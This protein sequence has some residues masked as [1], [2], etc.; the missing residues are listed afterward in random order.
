MADRL[1]EITWRD[2]VMDDDP[3]GLSKSEAKKIEPPLYCTVGYLLGQSE[4]AYTLAMSRNMEG[5]S[6]AEV[7]CIPTS[8]VVAWRP[9]PD[10]ANR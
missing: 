5:D 2:S 10:A 1:V 6:Y 9:I 4:D 7:L 8:A 3:G